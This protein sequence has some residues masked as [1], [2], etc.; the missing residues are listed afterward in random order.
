MYN[1][2]SGAFLFALMNQFSKFETLKRLGRKIINNYFLNKEVNNM[3]DFFE[4]SAGEEI[5]VDTKDNTA[6]V[7]VA[8][9]QKE[10]FIYDENNN[11][12]AQLTKYEKY[13]LP[14]GTGKYVLKYDSNASWNARVFIVHFFAI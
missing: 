12:I 13:T 7:I 11:K 3:I 6:V 5:I 14:Y 2:K 1:L 8:N 9:A 4:L 10:V